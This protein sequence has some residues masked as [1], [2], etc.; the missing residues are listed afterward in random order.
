MNFSAKR[1]N[2]HGLPTASRCIDNVYDRNVDLVIPGFQNEGEEAAWWQ[3]LRA[4]VEADLRTS[5]RDAKTMLS[6]P[7]VLSRSRPKLLPVTIRLP[8]EDISTA[9]RLAEDKG[10]GYQTYIKLLLREALKRE[11]GRQPRAG[12]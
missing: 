8:S 2:S 12:S 10:I 7:D 3:K 5:L 4:A 6:L 11:A 1:K 9:R